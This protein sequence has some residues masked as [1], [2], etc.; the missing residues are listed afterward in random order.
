MSR[1]QRWLEHLAN[2]SSDPVVAENAGRCSRYILR[3]EKEG[4]YSAGV[5][6]TIADLCIAFAT[7]LEMPNPM[8]SGPKAVEAEIRKAIAAKKRWE[9]MNR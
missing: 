7:A 9:E 5:R 3:L 1:E 8:F 6:D 4:D 2:T